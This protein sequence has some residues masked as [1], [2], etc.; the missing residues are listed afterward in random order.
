MA[1]S[2]NIP[3]NAWLNAEFLLQK[4]LTN[5][6]VNNKILVVGASL[7]TGYPATLGQLK[8]T[9]FD[10]FLNPLLLLLA[11]SCIPHLEIFNLWE[12]EVPSLILFQL[13]VN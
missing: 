8:L 6:H 4:L 2:S 13:S 11:E 3:S 5:M 12:S 7:V 10:K 1:V 9:I